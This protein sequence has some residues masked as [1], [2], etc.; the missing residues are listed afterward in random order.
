MRTRHSLLRQSGSVYPLPDGPTTVVTPKRL[1]IAK[2][3]AGV[4][5][6]HNSAQMQC[7]FRDFATRRYKCKRSQVKFETDKALRLVRNAVVSDER[8]DIL[9]QTDN[10]CIEVM[11]VP[12]QHSELVGVLLHE[13]MHNWCVVR[14]K[15]MSCCNE[16]R[17]MGRLGDPNE[18]V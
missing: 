18:G 16:H 6:L 15:Y 3:Q 13:A 2:W 10:V 5:F 9:A 1:Q 4:E 17:C 11:R 7:T 8:D 12:M 14:G